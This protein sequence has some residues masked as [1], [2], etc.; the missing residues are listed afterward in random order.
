[1]TKIYKIMDKTTWNNAKEIG[2]F[3]GSEH[4]Q[5]DGFI[6]FSTEEQLAGTLAKHYKGQNDLLLLAFSASD[7]GENLKWEPSRGGAL[8]PHL[9][10]PL[11]TTY[12]LWEKPLEITDDGTH[13]IPKI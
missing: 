1:M 8:F 7:F 5:R 13:I 12:V 6:H 9:Y 11:P 10:T 2:E 3:K 4:D